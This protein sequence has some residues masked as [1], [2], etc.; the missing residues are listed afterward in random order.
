VT[1]AGGMLGRKLTAALLGAAEL[2]GRRI[3]RLTLTDL[4]LSG[5]APAASAAAPPG[6]LLEARSADLA[7]P[8]VA[9]ALVESRPH[10][11][12]HLAAVVS[13]EAEAD[14]EKG[15]RVNLEATRA[16][17]EAI[18]ARGPGYRPRV[19]FASSVFGPPL[20]EIIGDAQ[21]LTPR[22]SYGTQKAI[23]EMLLADYTRRGFIDGVG[24]RL[25]TLSIRPG[26]SNSALSGFFS[27]ILREPLNGRPAVLPVSDTVRHCFASPRAAVQFLVHAANIDAVCL[28]T[29]SSLNMPGLSATVADQIAALRRVAGECAVGLIRREPNPAVA[30]VIA[31]WPRRIDGRRAEALGFRAESSFDEIIRTYIDDELG[32]ALPCGRKR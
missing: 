18:R 14:F 16:L 11:I 19:V 13:G 30:A 22:S 23:G 12:F 31:G 3:A 32:G 1:G 29:E 8:G 20:P 21:R 4:E 28:G 2:A 25:P 26:R 17:F 15:Y 9:A 5:A 24:I 10:L 6:V 7:A 27:S